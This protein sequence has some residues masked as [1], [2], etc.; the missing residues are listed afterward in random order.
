MGMGNNLARLLYVYMSITFY[1]YLFYAG[2]FI[3]PLH[4]AGRTG[5]SHYKFWSLAVAVLA[6]AILYNR[7]GLSSDKSLKITSWA[8]KLGI[9]TGIRLLKTKS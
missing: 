8:Y 2:A 4:S 3:R 1:S 5:I 7:Y 6:G 9:S